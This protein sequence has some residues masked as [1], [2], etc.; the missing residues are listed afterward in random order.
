MIKAISAGFIFLFTLMVSQA[1][2]AGPPEDRRA[3]VAYFE[4][5]FP[6]IPFAEYANGIYAIDQDARNQWQEIEEFPP[7]EFA[8]ERG[9]ALWQ[10]SFPDGK[11]YADCFNNSENGVRQNY[12]KFDPQ[13]GQVITLEG[14]INLCRKH[15]GQESLEYGG[16]KMLALSAFMAFESRGKPFNIIVAEDDPRALAAYEEGKQFYYSK[17]GQMNFSCADCHVV[18][19]GQYVR[20]DHLSASLGHPTHFPV[21]RSK[22][23]SMLSLHQR[24][25]GCIRDVRAKPF[26]LQSTEYK[27]LEYFL[28]Y[29]SNGLQANGPGARK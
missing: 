2:F 20:A 16:E 23:G 9:E 29:M 8:V 11:G 25:A 6:D 28:T 15:H 1:A 27:A 4:S 3:F 21:Y 18:S 12:P 17:R 26:E 10:E 22:F 14:A 7:Y 5:R 19:A 13:I 24:V